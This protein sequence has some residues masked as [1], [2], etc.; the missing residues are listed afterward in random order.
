MALI[1]GIISILPTLV[2]AAITLILTLVNALMVPCHK[3]S[4]QVSNC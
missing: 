4:A 2:A 3:S 1:Q